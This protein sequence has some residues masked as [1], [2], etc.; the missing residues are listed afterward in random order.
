MRVALAAA[1][2]RGARGQQAVEATGRL[3]IPDSDFQIPLVH[4]E[5]SIDLL[6]WE[7]FPSRSG[8]SI[9]LFS[10]CTTSSKTMPEKSLGIQ[11]IHDV[12]IRCR[13]DN[14][15]NLQSLSVQA[16]KS[17]CILYVGL[18]VVSKVHFRLAVHFSMISHPPAKL[19]RKLLQSFFPA[20]S[21]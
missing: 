14:S 9:R 15:V 19:Q 2:A 21:L 13:I 5:F 20:I 12:G 4:S 10:P 7:S 1:H 17:S 3:L 6:Q 11:P 18:Y 16:Q 8:T